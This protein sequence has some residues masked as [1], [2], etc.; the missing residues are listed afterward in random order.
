MSGSNGVNMSVPVAHFGDLHQKMSRKI[1]QL[2]KV[3][4]HLNNKGEDNDFAVQDL[5]DQY[6]SE[7]ESILRDAATKINRFKDMVNKEKERE[8]NVESIRVRGSR[9]PSCGAQ[10]AGPGMSYCCCLRLSCRR[11]RS[12]TRR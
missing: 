2:S 11:R 9:V 8:M 6:E 4:Y 3:I 5:A 12:A 10:H 1:A 7:I